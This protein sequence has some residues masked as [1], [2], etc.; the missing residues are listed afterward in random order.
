[1]YPLSISTNTVKPKIYNDDNIRIKIGKY[2]IDQN[3]R[4]YR[5]IF[6]DVSNQEFIFIDC[7][8]N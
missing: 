4:S 7:T 5:I 1:M 3:K 8:I 6:D 2:N